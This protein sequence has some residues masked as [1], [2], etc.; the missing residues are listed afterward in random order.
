MTGGAVG[1][2]VDLVRVPQPGL[3]LRERLARR[4]FHLE[5]RLL[6][7]QVLFRMAVAVQ[8]PLHLQ[9]VLLVHQRHVV[10]PAVAGDAG[11]PLGEVHAVVEEDEISQVVDPVPAQRLPLGVAVAHR[12]QNRRVVP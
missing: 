3:Q 6:R 2:R 12:R 5:E 8:A 4:V 11:H 7:H 1:A 9:R 10:H